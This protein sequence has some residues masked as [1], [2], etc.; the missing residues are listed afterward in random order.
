MRSILVTI[1]VAVLPATSAL[2]EPA[3][4]HKPDRHPSAGRVLPPKGSGTVNSCAEFGPG[5]VKVE[6]TDTCMRVGGGISIGAGGSS[7]RR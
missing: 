7:G 4:R 1:V 5:F 6:G 2:A 3:G